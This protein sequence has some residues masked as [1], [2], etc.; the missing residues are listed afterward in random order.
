[1]PLTQVSGRQVET[2]VT[3][4]ELDALRQAAEG[5]VCL[6]L[7]AFYGA[8]TLAMASTA[9]LVVS[10]DWH[11]GDPQAGDADT[12]SLYLHHVR[13]QANVVPVIGRF[14]QVMPLLRPTFEFVF[15]D[16]FHEYE[17]ARQDAIWAA[18]LAPKGL[19]AFHDWGIFD[20]ERAVRSLG[21]VPE[22]QVQSLAFVRPK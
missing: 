9:K 8:S 17:A 14:E 21:L 5:R 4:G 12:L 22:H 18:K 7:G 15:V 11:R 10:V 2:W 1:M 19:I 13:D 6:E 20:V 16:G 3:P